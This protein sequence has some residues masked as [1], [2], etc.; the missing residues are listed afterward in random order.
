MDAPTDTILLCGLHIRRLYSDSLAQY[1]YCVSD[2]VQTF[3]PLVRIEMLSHDPLL[4]GHCIIAYSN[5]FLRW[6]LFAT[7]WL[8][9][10]NEVFFDQV[11]DALLL[12]EHS[13]SVT[14]VEST[15]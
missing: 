2:I 10:V 14:K 13:L 9:N 3:Q 7:T 8:R 6:K 15:F 4:A 12:P 5:L 1:A 11:A